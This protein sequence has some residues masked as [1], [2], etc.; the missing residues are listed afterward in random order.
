MSTQREK[1]LQRGVVIAIALLLLASMAAC[2]AGGVQPTPE[3]IVV[4]PT[5]APEEPTPVAEEPTPVVEEP[6][7]VA[8]EPTPQPEAV[9]LPE[10]PAAGGIVVD[11]TDPGFTIEEGEWGTCEN[12]NCQG[13][14]YG[15]DFRFADPTC[16]SCRARFDFTI[17]TAG[18]YDVL[19][20]W[21]W[22]E[23][24][25][26]DAPYTVNYSG[27]SLTFNVDM[28]NN[29]DAWYWLAT[30]P[31]QA[32]E[33]VSVVVEGTASGFANADAVA[34]APTGAG[35]PAEVVAE[36]PA[37]EEPA[38]GKAPV[39]QYFRSEESST[40]G[41]YYLHWDVSE[42]TE[43]YLDDELVDNPGSTEVCPE[44]TTEY[45]LWAENAAGDVEQSLTVEV[46]AAEAPAAPPTPQEQPAAAAGGEFRR[47]MFLHHSCGHNLIDQGGVRQHLTNLGY[48][49]YDHCY[50]EEGLRLADGSYAGMNFDVPGDNT[51][52]DGL[53]FIFAQP[54]HD[55]PDNT[56]SHLMQYDVIAFKSCFPTSLIESD[57]ML[58]QY[59]SYYLSIRDRADQY[60][61][62]IFIAVTQPPEI[63]NDT[64]AAMAGRA[65]A[66]TN[67]VASDEYLGGHPNVFTFNFFDLLADPSTNMLRSEYQLDPYDAHPNELANQ[68]IGP[69]FADFIDQAIKTYSQGR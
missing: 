58:A 47:V 54:L 52:P 40:A 21:P 46:G 36:E 26:T 44:Q 13:T 5:P 32:G 19:A 4:T 8:E 6:A 30:L 61:N 33:T 28:P 11:N 50:N 12:G 42:A 2:Q 22:G 43:V 17:E 48:E 35:V 62:K 57:E 3:V 9:E 45:Y 38:A 14:C 29:G 53:A 20:W 63:P 64:D 51:D 66:F 10:P 27:G 56:F 69:I 68:T 67:W 15:P 31:F 23:D 34:L 65:R 1:R 49:F 25:A 60:P 24:R 55:P 7:P 39:V 18:E 16:T 41:C 37:T 59:K